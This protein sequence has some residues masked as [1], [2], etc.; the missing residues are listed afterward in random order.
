MSFIWEK[1]ATTEAQQQH[2]TQEFSSDVAINQKIKSVVEGLQPNVKRLFLEFSNETD[3]ELIADF[4]RDCERQENIALGTKRMYLI[5]LA[6]LSRHFNY[7]KSFKDLTA[8]DI[9][10]FLNSIYKNGNIDPEQ[11]WI[12]TRNQRAM[13]I[14]K[15]Y[16]WVAFPHKTPE[17]RRNKIPKDQL[18]PVLKGVTLFVTKKG[19]KS[20]IKAS[21]IWK[22]EDIA[23]ALKFLEGNPRL[24]CYIAISFDTAA[25]PN[26]LLQT[27]LK[28]IEPL[29]DMNTGRLVAQIVVGRYG[30]K[31]KDR[32]LGIF[33]SFK[34]YRAWRAVHPSAGNPESFLF[35]SIEHS[36]KYRNAA[37]S[38]ESLRAELHKLQDQYFP[39][40]LKRSDISE[41]DKEKIKKLLT[42]KF[43]SYTLRHSALS[44]LARNPKLNDYQRRLYAGWTKSSDMIEVYTHE[45]PGDSFEDVMC[46]FGV[47][48]KD[49]KQQQ[50]LEQQLRGKICPHCNMENLPSAQFCS[51]CKLVLTL[52]AFNQSKEEAERTKSEMAELHKLFAKIEENETKLKQR[53]EELAALQNHIMKRLAWQEEQEKLD[54]QQRGKAK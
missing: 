1:E 13:V 53:S 19:S 20:P 54:H 42:K 38:V 9:T 30:K 47:E 27:R 43:T 12:R 40:L 4:L 7:Q 16:K 49:K 28:D 46:A 24:A 2:E 48:L 41:A 35:A 44:R 8:K 10:E 34:Y 33:D 15:F 5:N 3:K 29:K 36:A 14:S 45:M 6:Y 26:E 17:E 22:Q 18:P 51:E 31:K 11:G 23:T 50:E 32:A 37:I 52:E 39:S 21:D 25:R